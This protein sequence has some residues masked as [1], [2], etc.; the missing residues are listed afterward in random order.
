MDRSKTP[1]GVGEEFRVIDGGSSEIEILLYQISSRSV[2]YLRL[3]QSYKEIDSDSPS[4]VLNVLMFVVT[5]SKLVSNC[6]E[7][8]QQIVWTNIVNLV[9]ITDYY[10][11]QDNESANKLAK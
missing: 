7:L 2:R 9:W 11:I 4:V 8:L 1:N 5:I 10:G 3:C 6:V